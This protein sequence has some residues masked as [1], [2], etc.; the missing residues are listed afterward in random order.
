MAGYGTRHS[1]ACAMTSRSDR[2]PRYPVV[3]HQ[4]DTEHHTRCPICGHMVDELEEVLAHLDPERG[5]R[6]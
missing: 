2:P 5:A 4:P 1:K 3:P 6:Q